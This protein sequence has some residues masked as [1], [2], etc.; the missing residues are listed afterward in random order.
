M[1]CSILFQP[2]K[3]EST[4]SWQSKP[5]PGKKVFWRRW[6]NSPGGKL[7]SSSKEIR[8]Q[9]P[10]TLPSTHIN[11][12]GLP[13]YLWGGAVVC[14]RSVAFVRFGAESKGSIVIQP[15][16]NYRFVSPRKYTI[17]KGTERPSN[18]LLGLIQRIQKP[19][20]QSIFFLTG[21]LRRWWLLCHRKKKWVQNQRTVDLCEWWFSAFRRATLPI[22]CQPLPQGGKHKSINHDGKKKRSVPPPPPGVRY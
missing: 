14:K 1:L 22:F 11:T 4:K 12:G 2:S 7:R 5:T 9:R 19:T 3:T 21:C 6:N 17:K 18:F 16:L 15:P 20:I 10:S 8:A 13:I